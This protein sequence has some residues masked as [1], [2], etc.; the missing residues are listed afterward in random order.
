[1]HKRFAFRRFASNQAGMA[2]VEFALLAPIMVG[3][4]LG[5]VEL[6]DALNASRRAENAASLADVVARDTEVDDDEVAGFWAGANLLMF[7]DVPTTTLDVRITS[8][9]IDSATDATVVWSE[10][11]NA[12]SPFGAGSSIDLPD[13]MMT[14]GTSVIMAETIYHYSPPLRFLFGDSLAMTHTAYR[15]S[16][17][18][19]PIPR[20]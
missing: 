15:R 6:I 16:R 20:A 4:L 9:S 11:H 1:M 5:T 19:D 2:A 14:P 8:I 3:L 17:V 10:G 18:I 12:L 13:A 7:P